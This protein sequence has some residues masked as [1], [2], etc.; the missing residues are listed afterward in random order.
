[1]DA[2]P[3]HAGA[4]Q[5]YSGTETSQKGVSYFISF[6]TTWR[7]PPLFFRNPTKL[8][9]VT[10]VAQDQSRR[11]KRAKGEVAVSDEKLSERARK[12]TSAH[13]EPP[14]QSQTW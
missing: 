7:T 6:I 13:P 1:V 10:T 3:F 9:V 12:L 4:A 8:S 11:E 5:N 2:Q 14:Q